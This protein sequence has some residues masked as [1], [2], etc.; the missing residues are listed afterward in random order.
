MTEE[1][2]C[3]ECGKEIEMFQRYAKHENGTIL[4]KACFDKLVESGEIE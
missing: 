4:C 1:L 3:K 2:R